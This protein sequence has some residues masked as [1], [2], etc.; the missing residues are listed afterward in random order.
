VFHT[1]GALR[2][3]KGQVYE[4]GLRVPL[5]A[6]WPGHVPAGAVVET[7]W[8]FADILPTFAELAAAEVPKHIDGVSVVPTLLGKDQDLSQRFLYWEQTTNGLVQAAR[9]GDWKAVQPGRNA[10]LELYN[11]KTDP[12]ESRNVAGEQ[13]ELVRTFAEH[14]GSARTESEDWPTTP[15]TA[16]GAQ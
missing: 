3:K 13:P 8:Y 14:L 1:N 10:A 6:R 9:Q 7:P 16:A 12:T 4:G 11:L 5:I 2:G 15:A